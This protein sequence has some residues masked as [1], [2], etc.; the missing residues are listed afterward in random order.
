MS[1]AEK[2]RIKLQRAEVIADEI[3]CD[4]SPA[5]DRIK[6]AGSI[7]RKR[8]EVGD[9][10][11]VCIPR[12]EGGGLFGDGEPIDL[13]TKVCDAF[14]AS[15]RMAHRLDKNGRRSYGGKFK[16]LLFEGFPLDLF[17]VHDANQWGVIFAIRTGPAEFS[18][19][20]VTQKAHGGHMPEGY[21]VR[22]GWLLAHGDQVSC[23]E[24]SDFFR[25]IG[26]EFV[27]PEKRA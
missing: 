2:Q 26:M 24:E 6:I 14:L 1:M 7:R 22:D 19:R 4:L 3:C 10:E 25:A 13:V 17:S 23:P 21:C 12:I 9:V 11:I 8:S 27:A 20:F 5:C 15:G 16:R 18:K